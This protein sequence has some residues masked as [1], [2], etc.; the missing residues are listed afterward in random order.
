MEPTL[1]Q[2]LL[3]RCQ[4]YLARQ[5]S[6]DWIAIPAEYDS[7]PAEVRRFRAGGDDLPP[8]CL[9]DATRKQRP[10]HRP[11][12]PDRTD[13]ALATVERR[14]KAGRSTPADH[15][16][17]VLGG[18]GIGLGRITAILVQASRRWT[19]RS[20]TDPAAYFDVGLKTFPA[21]LDETGNALAKA[22][23]LFQRTGLDL[24]PLVE[25]VVKL[26]DRAPWALDTYTQRNPPARDRCKDRY[27]DLK[28]LVL[29]AFKRRLYSYTDGN[30][31]AVPQ[32]PPTA[33][34]PLPPGADPCGC[35]AARLRLRP[36]RLRPAF[37][38][39]ACSRST[40][41]CPKRSRGTPTRCS[42]RS[43]PMTSTRWSPTC[44]S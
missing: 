14:A 34:V 37:P 9:T 7:R 30:H 3:D 23:T 31:V 11:A 4:E 35:A 40:S 28:P 26:L 2:Q 15:D 22:W 5:A 18:G 39:R 20:S 19:P 43:V 44:A 8:E 42:R 32:Y 6:W 24:D 1:R 16:R 41:R 12:V 27:P 17:F 36:P 10:L 21:S 13:P 29:E 33:Q 38:C 25:L